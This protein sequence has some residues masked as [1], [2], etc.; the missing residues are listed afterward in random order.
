M[1][2][3]MMMVDEVRPL[4]TIAM[5]VRMMSM[6]MA[7]VIWLRV[8]LLRFLNSKE[9]LIHCFFSFRRVISLFYG[10]YTNRDTWPKEIGLFVKIIPPIY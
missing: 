4:M 1:M 3:V 9:F 10:R 8:S 2:I 6:P 7:R 5:V